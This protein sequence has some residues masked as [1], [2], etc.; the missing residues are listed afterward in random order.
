MAHVNLTEMDILLALVR[1]SKKEKS[2]ISSRLI[3]FARPPPH[4]YNN[5]KV[6]IH[7]LNKDSI[8]VNKNTLTRKTYYRFPQSHRIL[9]RFGFCFH[10][11][12]F[13]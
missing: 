4:L 6:G 10:N 13:I 12:I 7:K 2:E 3:P 1:L 9:C 11:F 8:N 5:Y